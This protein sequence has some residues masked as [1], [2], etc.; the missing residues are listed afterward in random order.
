M[1]LWK[2]GRKHSLLVYCTQ[3]SQL[4]ISLSRRF[5]RKR[6]GLDLLNMRLAGREALV[7]TMANGL[8]IGASE[9]GMMAA[10]ALLCVS[11]FW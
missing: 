10:E 3:R 7:L 1:R 2:S 9:P 4:C 6:H 5:T 8:G 11:T